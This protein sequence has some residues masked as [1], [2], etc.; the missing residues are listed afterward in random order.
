MPDLKKPYDDFAAIVLGASVFPYSQRITAQQAF[1]ESA[2]AVRH[3]LQSEGG[4]H[5]ADAN[6]LWLFDDRATVIGQDDQIATFLSQISYEGIIFYYVG[7]G[8]FLADREYFLA[9]QDTKINREH[10][11]GY[12][13]KAL[14]ETLSQ[15]SSNKKLFLI[16]D[17][18]FAGEAVREFQSVD[19][20]EVVQRET[21]SALPS[22]GTSLLVAASKDEPAISPMGNRFTMFSESLIDVLTTGIQGKGERL[23]L[24]EVGSQVQAL[25]RGRYGLEGVRPEV[26]SPQQGGI[27][28]ATLPIFPNPRFADGIQ[29]QQST[30]RGPALPAYRLRVLEPKTSIAIGGLTFRYLPAATFFMGSDDGYDH[31]RPRHRVRT[32]S[33]FLQDAPLTNS[34]FRAFR[35]LSGYVS[36]AESGYPTFCRIEDG[37]IPVSGHN[38][39]NLC[40]SELNSPA[41]ANHPVV[42]MSW[43]DAAMFCRWMSSGSGLDFTLP[44]EAQWEYAASGGKDL[45]WPFG[46][47]YVPGKANIQSSGTIDVRHFPPTAFQLFDMAGNVYEWCR[48]WYAQTWQSAGHRLDEPTTEPIGPTTGRMRVLRGGSWCDEPN[49]CRCANRFRAQPT[50]SAANWGFR[51]ALDLNERLIEALLQESDWG[52]HAQDMMPEE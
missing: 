18:C 43:Y 6:I 14:A 42:H 26:H 39:D 16:L 32:S 19:L 15:F 25:I 21:F 52:L 46:D 49:H 24:L 1:A 40:E 13:I 34:A 48:D 50:Q 44:T 37:W 36:S 51:C 9:I 27:D 11:T 31:E 4:L 30:L 5:L 12:R 7:H 33:F 45:R 38:W 2:V 20:S 29:P 8:G 23:S 28:V 22:A 3:Y 47:E 17:C 35:E 10:T 41:R